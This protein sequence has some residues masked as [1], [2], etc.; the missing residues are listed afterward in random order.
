MAVPQ[1]STDLIFLG[2]AERAANIRE[3]NAP[4]LKWNVIGLKN[5]L[6][7][8]FTPS[9]VDDLYLVFALRYM[10]ADL[11]VKIILRNDEGVS[12]ARQWKWRLV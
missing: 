8:L 6:P 3:G 10:Q 12:N 1:K 5:Y 4:L 2:I 7:L 11:K 9:I